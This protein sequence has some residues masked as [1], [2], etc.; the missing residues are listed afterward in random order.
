MIATLERAV[1]TSNGD[2]FDSVLS[3]DVIW[4]SPKGQIV[5]GLDQLNPI[6]RRLA[7]H[8]RA[9]RREKFSLQAKSPM[10]S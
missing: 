10:Q 3:E 2:L 6:H 1:N 7:A 4:G 8:S 9:C 5:I